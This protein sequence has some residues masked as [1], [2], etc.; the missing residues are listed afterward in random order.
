MPATDM[1]GLPVSASSDA[2]VRALDSLAEGYLRYRADTPQRLARLIEVGGDMP[3]AHVLKGYLTMLAFKEP[4]VPVARA[5]L[6]DAERTGSAA[7]AREKAHIA[8]LREWCDGNLDGMLGTWERILEDHPHDVMAFRLHHFQAFWYGMPYRMARQ[9][10][11]TLPRWSEA[12]PYYASILA[13]HCFAH[14][15]LGNYTTAENSG[16]RALELDPADLWAAHAVA[17]VLEMQGRRTEGIEHLKSLE[18]HWSGGNHFMHHLWWHLGLYHYERGELDE[19]LRLYDTKYRNHASPLN[20]AVPD[21]YVDFQNAASMLFRLERQGIDVGNRWIEIADHAEKRI[22][23]NRSPFTQT[24]WMMALAATRRW[25]AA[26]RMLAAMRSYAETEKGDLGR[27]V[28]RISLPLCEAIVARGRGDYAAAV[29]RMRPVLGVMFQ[30]GGS[31][32]QQDVLEQVFLDCAEK[33]RSND[34]VRLIIERVRARHP[35]PPER[36]AGYRTSAARM[37]A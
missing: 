7:T 1:Y 22:G 18:P 29:E 20:K 16:R 9:V 11:A 27:L 21:L 14:E 33:A 17:H 28:K 3:M 32:A 36:R 2:A 5:A 15:E 23:D 24:H 6:A 8:A 35:V 12:Q 37:H 30:I 25:E 31:H 26:E 10:E 13:C 34:A 19:V 4:V